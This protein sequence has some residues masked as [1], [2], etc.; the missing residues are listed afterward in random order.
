MKTKIRAFT[1]N[2]MVIV[3][4]I[5]TIVI[6]IAFTVLSLVQRHMWSIQQ[7]FKLNTEFNRL[8]QALWIDTNNYS[9]IKYNKMEREIQFKTVLDSTTY[10]FKSDYVLRD[11]D[12][13]HVQIEQKRFFFDGIKVSEGMV[14]AIQLNLSAKFKDQ[15]I[16][17]F[18]HNDAIQFIK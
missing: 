6:G 15:S 9:A 13:F 1:L 12:T 16:F 3:M 2:E 5:S 7:N 14:D 17:V 8:E 18:K 11:R 4:I 10:H